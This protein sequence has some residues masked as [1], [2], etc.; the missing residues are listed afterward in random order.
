MNRRTLLGF[1]FAGLLSAGAGGA[2][3]GA[4]SR[5]LA[6]ARA[7][8]DPSR[9][10]LGESRFG[11][12]E[13][14]TRGDGRPILMIHGTGGGFDQGL[15]FTRRLLHMGYKVI[16]PSRFG[17][18][19]SSFPADPSSEN[20]ADA[21]ADLL[22][23]LHIDRLPVLGGSAGALSA[24]AFALRHPHRCAALVPIVPAT[25][26]PGRPPPRPPTALASAIIEYALKS[27]FLFW[28]GLRT[29]ENS[30]IAALLATDP[31]LVATASQEERDRVRGILWD[32]L[33]VSARAK[34]FVN[35]AKLAGNPAP[36]PIER[37]TAP[38]LAISTQDDR[39]ETYAAAKHIAA[40]VPGAR[41][42]SFPTGGHVWVGHDQEMFAQIDA[43]I[44]SV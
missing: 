9:S 28:L 22:D 27:D 38:T 11:P 42:F 10:L 6:S 4:Y 36:M 20:Q 18:L 44:R 25:H 33:P 13:Y 26:V 43:F 19:R 34:G 40:T 5:D 7:R 23:S 30:M 39:F 8:L 15:G 16:A 14:A 24:L 31:E 2:I 12:I 17:Y 37:I 32:I 21:F 41:L 35:D 3:W 29:A 1:G